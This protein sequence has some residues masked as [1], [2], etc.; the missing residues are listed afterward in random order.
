[1]SIDA[2]VHL[3]VNNTCTTLAAKKDYLLRAMDQNQ[4]DRCIVISDSCSISPICSADECIALFSEEKSR[5]SV[6][7]GIS[8][9]VDVSSQLAKMEVYLEQNS[10]VGMKLFPG[11]EAFYLT[12]QR[13][14]QIYRLA[15]HYDVP[16]LFH[17]GGAHNPYSYVNE[18]KAVLDRYP[19]IKLVCCHCFYPDLSQCRSLLSYPNLYFDISSVAD[20]RRIL[21][22]TQ[23]EIKALITQAPERVLFG[24]DAF[25]CSIGAH[26]SLVKGLL[27]PPELEERVFAKNAVRLYSM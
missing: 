3:P 23:R 16:V 2:H 10:L 19:K 15:L 24:S 13:L 18:V 12:D 9:L 5:I 8:P 27:L 7:G 20:D 21:D 22:F 14:D 26:I 25:G 11:H 4:L 6:V 17:S 1:M